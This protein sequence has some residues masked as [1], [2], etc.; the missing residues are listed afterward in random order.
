MTMENSWTLS[1]GFSSADSSD[2]SLI[3]GFLKVELCRLIVFFFFNNSDLKRWKMNF[4]YLE[5]KWN[6]PNKIN[7]RTNPWTDG[8]TEWCIFFVHIIYVLPTISYSTPN[9][10]ELRI[11]CKNQLYNFLDKNT[12]WQ[13][14]HLNGLLSSLWVRKW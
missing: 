6:K 3:E 1:I 9:K 13:M 8:A 12:F 5:N 7:Y 4:Y 10:V 11:K 14:G 2:S